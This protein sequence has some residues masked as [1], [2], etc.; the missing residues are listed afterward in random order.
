M[1][2][3]R[4]IAALLL[5]AL[6]LYTAGFNVSLWW[7]WIRHKDYKGPSQLALFPG[8]VG[9]LSFWI[10]PYDRLHHYAWLPLVLDPGT[11]ATVLLAVAQWAKEAYQTNPLFRVATYR[12]RD[13]QTS[14]VLKLYRKGRFTLDKTQPKMIVHTG[15]DWAV[16]DDRLVLHSG[17]QRVAYLAS[18]TQQPERRPDYILTWSPDSTPSI[19]DDLDLELAKGRPVA[20]A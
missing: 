6:F 3:A 10:S 1:W 17:G 9:A 19:L 4:A 13:P 18:P 14:V 20:G 8:V 5:F 16:T 11:G 7:R 12:Y 15:G 2:A